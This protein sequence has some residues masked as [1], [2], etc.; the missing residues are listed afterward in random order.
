MFPTMGRVRVALAALGLTFA[1]LLATCG[2]GTVDAD[3]AGQDLTSEGTDDVIGSAAVDAEPDN[4]TTSSTT[5]T[6]F[7]TGPASRRKPA[8]A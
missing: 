7:D 6:A 5:A 1:I 8:L 4:A 2:G 3:T